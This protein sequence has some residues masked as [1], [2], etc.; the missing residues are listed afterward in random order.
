MGNQCSN[1]PPLG[2]SVWLDNIRRSMFASGELAKLIDQGLRGMTSN[3]TIFEKAIGAGNDYDE[4]LRSLIGRRDRRRR[5]S[6][7]HWRF[8]TSA[9][10]ATR[11]RRSSIRRTAADGYVSLEVSPTLA[12]DTQ[13]TIDA[14]A[15]LWKAVDRPNVMIKIPGTH[16]GVPGDSGL[17]RGRHQHQRDAACSPST[18]TRPLR[19]RTSTASTTASRRAGRSTKIAS[20]ASVFVSRIDTAVDKQLDERISK[21]E[22]ALAGLVGK[23]G[24]ANIKLI[25][26]KF[27]QLF[28]GAAFARC[29]L[30]RCARPAAALGIDGHEEPGFQRLDVRRESWSAKDTVNTM[31]PQTLDALLDHGKIRADAALERSRRRARHT[32]CA[33]QSGHIA[34]RRYRSTR[35]R[36]REIVRRLVRSNARGDRQEAASTRGRCGSGGSNPLTSSKPAKHL[37]DPDGR[38]VSHRRGA[39]RSEAPEKRDFRATRNDRVRAQGREH[40][41]TIA[42]GRRQ[43]RTAR[44]R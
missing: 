34:G 24:I 41:D 21:G 20:V 22:T 35:R 10:P 5:R 43:R 9:A 2:Q 4:Q 1:S 28:D 38:G 32:R 15:R 44:S 27:Q 18:P 23:T 29:A 19:R 6:S 12:H 11:S 31:P 30:E 17:D 14:A 37:A 13:G 40:G 39:E 36:R 7:R 42:A 26:Q 3:P 33:G 8:A 25:Y 16:E